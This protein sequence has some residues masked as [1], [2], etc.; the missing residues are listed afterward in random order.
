MEIIVKPAVIQHL[1]A[2]F[3][4]CHKLPLLLSPHAHILWAKLAKRAVVREVG[5]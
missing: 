2:P 4:G 5:R 3:G 1:F